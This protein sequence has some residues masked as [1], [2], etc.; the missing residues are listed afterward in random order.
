MVR[1]NKPVL[2]II[3]PVVGYVHHEAAKVIDDLAPKQKV[4]LVRDPNN[5]YDPNAIEVWWQRGPRER[6]RMLG[7][8]PAYDD[9]NVPL[10]KLM[11]TGK[12]PKA[13]IVVVDPMLR[14]KNH[15]IL[16]QVTVQ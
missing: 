3:C 4:T 6:K 10:A 13:R 7:F 16:I 9:T 12:E 5:P 11:D 14:A 15:R 8:V 1:L 2:E